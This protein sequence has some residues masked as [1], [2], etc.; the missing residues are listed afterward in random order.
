MT[1]KTDYTNDAQQRIL[2]V[3]LALFS[4]VVQGVQPTALAR[5]VGC[6][7]PQITR[8]LDNLATAG[9]AERDEA[10]GLWRLTPRLPQQSIKVWA[11]ISAAETRL[12]DARTR[13]SRTPI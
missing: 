8:D 4:D 12:Q 9:L 6:S 13:F 7:A 10:T 1:R 3:V 5:T 11:A 2:K